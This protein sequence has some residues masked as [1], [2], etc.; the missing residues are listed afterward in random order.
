M[1]PLTY[2]GIPIIFYVL[3]GILTVL[4][5]LT[6]PLL[7]AAIKEFRTIGN[8]IPIYRFMC[9]NVGLVTAIMAVIFFSAPMSES[10]QLFMKT[11][12]LV[13]FAW[14]CLPVLK[15]SLKRQGRI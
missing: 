13:A 10:R 7:F 8:I 9:V 6:I 1:Q 4:N 15:Y 5:G 3:L 11:F 12:P 2:L 14:F